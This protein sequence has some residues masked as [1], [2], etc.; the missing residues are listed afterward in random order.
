MATLTIFF[1]SNFTG[2][3]LGII[4]NKYLNI[5][6]KQTLYFILNN[7]NL[8]YL[9]YFYVLYVFVTTFNLYDLNIIELINNMTSKNENGEE[10][11]SDSLVKN[12]IKDNNLNIN[13]PLINISMTD[14]QV[15]RVV[16]AGSILGGMKI[17]M[18]AANKIPSVPGKLA[19]AAAG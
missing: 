4:I 3:I 18:E 13:N 15:K 17:G 11:T 6:Y 8:N 2:L 14:E 5:H 7:L 16:N 19:V 10:N 9:Y 12:D 1:I